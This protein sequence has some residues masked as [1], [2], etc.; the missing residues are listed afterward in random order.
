[1]ERI[2][3]DTVTVILNTNV[4]QGKVARRSEAQL[5]VGFASIWRALEAF[6]R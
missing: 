3:R 5:E 2:D 4:L 1:M 6:S